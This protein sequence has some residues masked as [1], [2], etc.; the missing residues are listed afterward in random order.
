MRDFANMD[1]YKSQCCDA[2]HDALVYL[3]NFKEGFNHPLMT[4]LKE[5]Y[6]IMGDTD[7]HGE[8]WY[9]NIKYCPF[10]GKEINEKELGR[11]LI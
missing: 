11:A 10:C 8:N 2:G 7:Q 5:G 1:F 3:E 4:S 9:W 6:F